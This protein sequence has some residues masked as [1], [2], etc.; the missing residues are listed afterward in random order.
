MK[1]IT[2]KSECS[3]FNVFTYCCNIIRVKK[4]QTIFCVCFLFVICTQLNIHAYLYGNQTNKGRELNIEKPS[5]SVLGNNED[6]NNISNQIP[7]IRS[8]FGITQ[9]M[10]S[11]R[12][13]S[14]LMTE[15]DRFEKDIAT[16]EN[17]FDIKPVQFLK[18]LTSPCWIGRLDDGLQEMDDCM[19]WT[20]DSVV[21]NSQFQVRLDLREIWTERHKQ[22]TRW[23]LRCLPYYYILG[24]PK[25]ATT[26]LHLR[27]VQ[28]PNILSSSAKEYH[29]WTKNRWDN[30]IGNNMMKH[31][32]PYVDAFDMVAENI[33]EEF[34]EN[35]RE[36]LITGDGTPYSVYHYHGNLDDENHLTLDVDYIT[37]LQ[38][39]KVRFIV[40]LRDPIARLYSDYFFWNNVEID[41]DDFSCRIN[42]HSLCIHAIRLFENCLERNSV[43]FCVYHQANEEGLGKAGMFRITVGIYYI[44]IEELL[45]R[46]SMKNLLILKTEEYSKSMRSTFSETFR[47]LGVPWENYIFEN[48]PAIVKPGKANVNQ[49]R[50]VM[51]RMYL[52]TTQML[53]DFYGKYNKKLSDL[54][55]GDTFQWGY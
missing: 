27:L 15:Y 29:F 18:H 20:S 11:N 25:C 38:Q 47:F 9:D 31:L 55:G 24:S 10:Y 52:Q 42:F 40:I 46:L 26:D 3:N 5:F 33:R 34:T 45:Q 48:Y 19:S 35:G 4:Y 23:R 8:L 7:A 30:D 36:E 32:K 2:F 16:K 17:I 53:Q 44:F 14:D 54:L 41:A 51:P 37:H 39:D 22:G 1:K 6:L 21:C 49:V 43:K 12:E 50:Q 28:H 13:L